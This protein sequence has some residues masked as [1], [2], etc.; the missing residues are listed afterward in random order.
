MIIKPANQQ[1]IFIEID[2]TEMSASQIRMIK[3]LN[4]LLSH[5]LVTE[6]E[7]EYF[8]NSAEVM[9]MAAALIKQANFISDMKANDIPYAEQVLE[10]SLDVLQDQ[11]SLS[12]VV[13]YDN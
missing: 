8:D 3:T 10:Y 13:S 6:S 1:K 7:G 4:S 12:K 9:R 2:T 5:V 11:M